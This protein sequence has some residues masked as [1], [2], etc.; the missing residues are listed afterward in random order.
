MKESKRIILELI[1]FLEDL[2]LGDTFGEGI[3]DRVE[4]WGLDEA[5]LYEIDLYEIF[6]EWPE[7]SGYHRFPVGFKRGSPELAFE[8]LPLW[9]GE[10]GDSRRR[11]ALF[12][13][14]W[15]EENLDDITR[16]LG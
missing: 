16:G 2:A 1:E 7:F 13:A 14:D 5:G 6:E 12:M 3:C 4:D 9:Q 8:S 11:L 10:Y 15:F